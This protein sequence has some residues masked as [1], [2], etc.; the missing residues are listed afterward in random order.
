MKIREELSIDPSYKKCLR[1]SEG[2][3]SGRITWEHCYMYKGRQIQEKWAIISLCVYHHLG[4]GLDKKM[5]HWF[6][7]NRMTPED[8]KKYDRFNWKREREILNKLYKK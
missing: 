6:S 4:D 3:C 2:Y 7:V 1:E 8:E 5:N